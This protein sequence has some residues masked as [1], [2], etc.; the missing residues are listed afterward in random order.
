MVMDLLN[1]NIEELKKVLD[2]KK[3]SS[4]ELTKFY[5]DRIEKYD[6][7]IGAYLTINENVLAEA[8]LIDEKRSRNENLPTFAGI[9]IA[10]KD[11]IITKGVKTSCASKILKDF[12][13]PYDATVSKLLKDYGFLILGKLNMDEFAM[14]SSNETSFFKNVKNPWDTT[15]VPGGSSGGAAASVAAGLTPFSIG[16][17][18]GGS[19]RQPASLCGVCGFKPTY[20]LVS[21]YGLIAFASSL[22]QIGPFSRDIRDCAHL[23]NVISG[24]DENDSTSYKIDKKDFLKNINSSIKGKKIG[25]PKEYFKSGIEADVL[26]SINEALEIYKNEGAEI[27]EISLPHSEYAVAVYYIIATAEASSNLARYD[28]VRYTYRSQDAKDIMDMYELS[29]SEGF[30]TEVKRRIMLGT[31]VL[32]AGYYDAYYLK[33]QK[34]RSLIKQDFLNAYKQVDV[35]LTPTSPNTAFKIG[36][37]LDDPISM[38]LSDIFTI[39]LNLFGGCGVSIPCGFDKNNLPV[40]LQLLGNYFEEDK[41]INYAYI[42]Q[43]NTEW[44][45]K[46]PEKFL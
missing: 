15:R 20:G 1:L 16:S 10:L 23:L 30:G 17:D 3:I 39:S 44:H 5:L 27:V 37:K 8:K 22:D 38:Y 34:V 18:T 13:P 42:F 29:R 25:I 33:A 9:P 12:N 28:G 7:E 40:G 2:E 45:K 36:E 14:G 11:N 19:I 26:D 4:Y 24:Y 21:R 32:S 41:I 31:Y 43:K 46:F 6:G 35:I